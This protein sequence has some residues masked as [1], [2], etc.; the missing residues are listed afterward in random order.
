MTNNKNIRVFKRELKNRN[1]IRI[2]NFETGEFTSYHQDKNLGFPF[3]SI[4]SETVTEMGYKN[5]KE[6]VKALKERNFLGNEVDYKDQKESE[7][8]GY[9]N[10]GV[11]RIKRNNRI[12]TLDFEDVI[13]RLSGYGMGFVDAQNCIIETYLYNKEVIKC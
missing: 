10:L 11:E 8:I 9:I 7:R 1:E 13:E 12:N 2:I 5:I 4:Q 6:C 3:G